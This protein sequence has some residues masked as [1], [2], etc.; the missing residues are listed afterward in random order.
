[1]Q[2]PEGYYWVKIFDKWRIAEWGDSYWWL[3]SI[4]FNYSDS[5]MQEVGQRIPS[6]EELEKMLQSHP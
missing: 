6:N 1:M 5:D 4:I 2:R 3:H